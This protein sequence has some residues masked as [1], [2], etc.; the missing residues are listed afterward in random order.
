MKIR[1][2]FVTNSSSSSFIIAAKKTLTDEQKNIIIQY[3]E[4]IMFQNKIASTKEELD[5]FWEI[6]YGINTKDNYNQNDWY[7]DEYCNALQNIENGF[8]LYITDLNIDINEIITKLS[9]DTNKLYIINSD[10]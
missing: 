10:L 7:Y 1:S 2:D 3:I 6:F 5:E 4:N 8:S 9:S